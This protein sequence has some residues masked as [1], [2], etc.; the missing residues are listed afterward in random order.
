[1]KVEI[2]V[3][4]ANILNVATQSESNF[5]IKEWIVEYEVSIGRAN[6][7]YGKFSYKGEMND[8]SPKKII[9]YVESLYRGTEEVILKEK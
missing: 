7:F 6:S 1:M 4:E 5:L 8:Q 2:K 9:E 3:I